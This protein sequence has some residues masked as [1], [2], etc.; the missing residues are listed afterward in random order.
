MNRTRSTI[1][2]ISAALMLLWAG[3]FIYFYASGRLTHYLPAKGL[4]RQLVL[5]SGIGM[6]VVGLFNLLTTDSDE[7]GCCGHDHDHDDHGHDHHGK[8]GGCCDHG[9]SHEHGHSHAHTHDH[10][11]EHGEC[12]GHDHSHDHKH[13]ESCGHDH[14]AATAQPHTHSHGILEE[15]GWMGRIAAIAILVLPLTLA[16][17]YSPDQFDVNALANKGVYDQDYNAKPQNDKFVIRKTNESGASTTAAVSPAPT[18]A[19]PAP[20]VATAKQPATMPPAP[21]PQATVKADQPPTA[22]ASTAAADPN[23]KSGPDDKMTSGGGSGGSS[24][25]AGTAAKAQSYGSFTL[26]DLKA[27]VPQ[28]KDG[29]FILD[30]PELYYTGGDVEVQRVLTGQSIETIAQ[31]LPEKVNNPDGKRIRIFRLLVQ[32]CAADARPYSV[33]VDFGKKA[34]EFKDM[35]WVKVVG[36]MTY[37]KEGD[38]TIPV[39]NATKIEETTAPS[40]TTLY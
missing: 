37:Q 22:A 28:S 6:A 1:H 29:N 23:A 21:L 16:A 33:P 7:A 20:E 25:E 15:S 32:C 30:V 27:Q 17:V 14:G 2:F 10:N 5:F 3:V 40:E 39:V 13:S 24:P 12:C 35:T 19:V 9:H 11:H 26:E 8:E 38:Q 18:P 4:F 34:P 36:T 31:V